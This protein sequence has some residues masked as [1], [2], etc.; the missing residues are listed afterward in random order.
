MYFQLLRE[1]KTSTHSWK[2]FKGSCLKFLLLQ[3]GCKHEQLKLRNITRMHF[4]YKKAKQN[5]KREKMHKTYKN[6]E[7]FHHFWKKHSHVWEYCMH[8]SPTICPVRELIVG[9]GVWYPFIFHP[10][11]F[12]IPPIWNFARPPVN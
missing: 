4:F 7:I 2:V 5:R 8:K 10:C 11:L 1:L 6:R 9:I 12:E 3:R